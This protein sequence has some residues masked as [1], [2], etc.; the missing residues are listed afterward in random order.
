M[1]ECHVLQNN[2]QLH[3]SV[4][5]PFEKILLVIK[6]ITALEAPQ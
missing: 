3:K 2:P 5:S 4:T 6:S 1:I